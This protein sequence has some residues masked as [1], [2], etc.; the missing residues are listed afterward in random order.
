MFIDDDNKSTEIDDIKESQICSPTNR[1]ILAASRLSQSNPF[2]SISNS[3]KNKSVLRPSI[4]T[5]NV[6]NASTR[7]TF[8]LNPSKLNTFAKTS[9]EETK[10][11]CDINKDANVEQK[12]TSNGD[13]LKFVPLTQAESKTS[14]SVPKTVVTNFSTVQTTFVFGQNLEERVISDNSSDAPKPSTS[15]TS[16]GTSKMLFCDAIKD[17]VKPETDVK[18]TKSLSESAKEYEESRANKRK[19]DEVEIRTGEEGETNVVHLSCK[20]FA[21]D[22]AG[23]WQERGRGNLRLNDLLIEDEEQPYTQSRLVFRTSG[24]LRVV[25]NTKVLIMDC[26][27]IKL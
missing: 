18:E 4:L 19:Y 11:N 17:K 26:F 23:S 25:L 3:N 27:I 1:N 24:S 12:N 8:A 7:T 14:E 9:V 2:G 5:T 16:N 13:S 10:D 21:F 15:L 6:N 22:K 20:L